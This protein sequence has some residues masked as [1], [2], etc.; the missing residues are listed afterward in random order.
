[1]R[2]LTL[3]DEAAIGRLI[4]RVA[5]AAGIEADT[6]TSVAAFRAQYGAAAPDAIVL[7]LH[8]GEADG[9]EQLRFL[10]DN[11]Y[12]G[13]VIVM[14]GLGERLL[15]TAQQIGEGLGLRIAGAIAKPVRIADLEDALVRLRTEL[16]SPSAAELR[17]AIAQDELMLE[18]QPIVDA[19]TGKVLSA[20]ALVR[21][22]HPRHGRVPPN[23]FIPLAESDAE[24][25]DGLTMWVIATAARQHRRLAESGIVL[26][27]SINISGKSLHQISFPDRVR[28][29]LRPY[30]TEH[31]AL[32]FEITETAAC[33][34]PI[35]TMDILARL[36][37]RGFELAIDDFGIGYSSLK[38]LKQ[39]PFSI[40]KIDQSFIADMTTSGDSFSIV[41]AVI[42]LARNLNMKSI[43][44]GVETA[45]TAEA[46]RQLQVTALQGYLVSRPVPLDQ[47]V[48]WLRGLDG[49]TA[50]D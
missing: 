26:P 40:I 35:R 6:T 41:K 34:D 32:A 48:E 3:D 18:L 24:L 27:I 46:L 23:R 20:E 1:M 43:A 17:A 38:V 8:I 49:A 37:I 7:D 14:S 19:Q 11:G 30:Q 22:I 29:V 36:R 21:W 28:E 45:E 4:A 13:P 44:E 12:R 15:A 5:E 16:W 31:G 25:I 39:L 42:D 47:L 9:I 2:I 50:A 10:S 33:E